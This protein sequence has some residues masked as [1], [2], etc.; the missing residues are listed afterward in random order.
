MGE[1]YWKRAGV[2]GAYFAFAASAV[3]PT[4]SLAW[5]RFSPA[6]A[7]LLSF[8]LAPLGLVA[9]S[10]TLPGGS[11]GVELA[12]HDRRDSVNLA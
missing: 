1:T 6:L 5:P 8:I 2:H 11:K 3:F 10:L 9:G 4:I 12:N 7:R